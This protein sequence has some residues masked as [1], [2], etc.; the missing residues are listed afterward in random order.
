MTYDFLLLAQTERGISEQDY[1]KSTFQ[2]THC[3]KNISIMPPQN[4]IEFCDFGFLG[5]RARMLVLEV[6]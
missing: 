6:F 5:K 1:I 2:S 3:T 4:L